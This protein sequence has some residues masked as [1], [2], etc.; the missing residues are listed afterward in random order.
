MNGE[1]IQKILSDALKM[2]SVVKI[3][4]KK[5]AEDKLVIPRYVESGRTANW[6]CEIF[7]PGIK[8]NDV[9]IDIPQIESAEHHI[10]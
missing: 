2:K 5:S 1:E 3:K 6:F 9:W 4:L 10:V 7:I 8:G